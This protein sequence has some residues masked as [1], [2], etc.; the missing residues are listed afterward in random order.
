MKITLQKLFLTF[1]ITCLIGGLSMVAGCDGD[2]GGGGGSSDD[3]QNSETVL[4]D[5]NEDGNAKEIEEW[6]TASSNNIAGEDP[7]LDANGS[8]TADSPSG[9][10]GTSVSIPSDTSSVSTVAQTRESFFDTVNYAGAFDPTK[11]AQNQWWYGWTIPHGGNSDA[12]WD[13]DKLDPST[14]CPIGE[15]NSENGAIC[16]INQETHIKGEKTLTNDKI[17]RL[18]AYLYVGKENDSAAITEEGTLNIE[19]GTKIEGTSSGDTTTTALVVQRDSK[20]NATG[21]KGEPIVMTAK[22]NSGSAKWGGLVIHG[23]AKINKGTTIEDEY[24]TGYYGGND[25]TDDSGKLEY[26]VV[27]HA[28]HR[29][30]PQSELN[31]IAFHAVGNETEINHIQ[32][33][34]NEDDGVEFFGGT[35]QAKYVYL[36]EN[37]DDSLDWTHGWRGKAQF[38]SIHK[39][40]NNGDQGIEA[41]NLEGDNTAQ[42]YSNPTISNVTMRGGGD[43]E[44]GNDMGML[45]RRGTKGEFY[46]FIITGFGEA[47]IDIDNEETFSHLDNGELKID[48]SLVSTESMGASET[49][50]SGVTVLFEE[51]DG[52]DPKVSGWFKDQEGNIAGLDPVL[53]EN[54][55]LTS[56]SPDG[57][58]GTAVSTSSL[59][60]SDSFFDT[61]EYV[62]AFDPT[63]SAQKQWWYGWTIPHG[64]N[65][66]AVW[67][68]SKLDANTDCV[69]G[70]KTGD[71]TVCEISQ[72]KHIN[73]DVTLTNDKIYRLK[74]Y[75]YVGEEDDNGN[76]DKTGTLDIEPG[77]KI[78]GTSSGDTTTTALVVQRDSKIN[79]TGTKGEPIVMTAKDNSGS[80]KWG[81]L[82]IHGNAKINKGTTIEDEYGTGYYGGNDDT[83]DSGKLEYLVVAH[84][85]HRY[86]PQSELNGIAFH[87]VGN[88]TEINHIQVHENE[89]DGVEFFGGTAQAKYV[90]LTEN[91][92]D[93]LDWTHGWH[94]KAQF[95]SIDKNHNNGDQGIEADNLE[96]DNMATPYSD[97]TIANLT[98]RGG[99]DTLIGNDMGMLLRRGTK[100]DFYNFIVTGFGEAQ[101]D[102]DNAE[103]FANAGNND[104]TMVNSLVSTAE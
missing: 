20:I 29:Y 86:N 32:V 15:K 100:G 58:R 76:I 50:D 26:L 56:S 28:G 46:G 21:T 89:D 77:T 40:Y 38:V 94:G 18:K 1:L 44:T 97:P 31:G 48:N 12:V 13:S 60:S 87:A 64:G 95:V 30:N 45:L 96:D 37:H 78:E 85:G 42:P 51:E 53:D 103:T 81:G 63:K 59:A 91:H 49:S 6:F 23:N 25:D 74:A 47:Q 80:A 98:M 99:G 41:D 75:L 102:I 68:D 79:A 83:D 5:N 88:E 84:A 62:G 104:L 7:A 72:E 33:H 66:D 61:T 11:S 36:T 39:N 93:S 82:V 35:A 92:D 67:D 24:G 2:D 90:Y 54:G 27:A 69:I 73:S 19:P 22:D 8:L 16:E 34:E 65:S 17:Y 101:I 14:K 4:F 43:R 57:L 55:S 10:N 71:G 3:S 70:Q 52:D 9:L